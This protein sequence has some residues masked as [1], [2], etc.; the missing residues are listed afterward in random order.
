MSDSITVSPNIVEN[1]F[2]GTIE[3]LLSISD[4]VMP[5]FM[6]TPRVINWREF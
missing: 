4:Y 2:N 5:Y 6:G 3:P 1:T